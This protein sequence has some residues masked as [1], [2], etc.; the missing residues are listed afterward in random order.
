MHEEFNRSHLLE[1]LGSGNLTV[2]FTK[3]STGELRTMYCTRNPDT[4]AKHEGSVPSSSF[5][6]RDATNGIVRVF[7]LEAK[8]WRSFNVSTIQELYVDTKPVANSVV[9]SE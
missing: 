3:I 4:I 8:G 2:K 6:E 5:E 1:L 7:D 9:F